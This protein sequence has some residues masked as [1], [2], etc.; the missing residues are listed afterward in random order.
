MWP[1]LL[2][3]ITRLLPGK[4]V[5]TSVTTPGLTNPAAFFDHMRQM[6]GRLS[7]K[8]VDGTNA[9]LDACKGWPL[10]YTAYALSTAY[11]ETAYT[12]QPIA[13]FGQGKGRRYGVP[14]HN[15]GQVAYG[16]GYV[17]LTWDENYEKADRKLGLNGALIDDYALALRPDIAAKI[18]RQGME[19][20]WFTA[21]K[22]ADYL[23]RSG[24]ATFG[25]FVLSRRIINGNDKATKI[26][27][28]AEQFQ[29]ALIAGGWR[30]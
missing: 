8:Q 18:L 4:A 19:E 26:A 10:A 12:M 21:K 14:G 29:A 16:R 9:V 30:A 23:P 2:D 24:P 15:R 11:H 20:G 22:L 6:R 3:A 13:E 27:K 25:Q 17:Q 7:A 28:E 5:A 1:K